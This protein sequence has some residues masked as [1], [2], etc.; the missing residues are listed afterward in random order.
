MLV[1]HKIG[2]DIFLFAAGDGV[3]VV[4]DFKPGNDRISLARSGLTFADLIMV[5]NG[6]DTI[7]IYGASD[8]VR[9]EDIAITDLTVLDFMF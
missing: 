5:E 1:R 4:T 9:L 7:I 3:D 2:L 8:I 6:S